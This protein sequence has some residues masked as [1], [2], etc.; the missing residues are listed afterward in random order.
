M[1]GSHY[2][3]GGPP[4][5]IA[6]IPRSGTSWIGRTLKHTAGVGYLHEPDNEKAH[7]FSLAAKRGLGRFPVLAP[8]ERHEA[9]ER[10]WAYALGA[11]RR[12]RTLPV[13]ARARTARMLLAGASGDDLEAAIAGRRWPV[14]LRAARWSSVPRVPPPGTLPVVKSVHAP[15]ALE[16]IDWLWA[17][18]VLV[19]FRH[20]LN[21]LASWLHLGLADRDRGL[22]RSEAVV[23]RYVRP[24]GVPLLRSGAGPLERAAWHYGLLVSALW[25]SVRSNPHWEVVRHE[26][27]CVDPG[28]SMPA[29]AARLGLVWTEGASEFLATSNRPGKGYKTHRIA[30]EQI[31]SWRRKLK[32]EEAMELR[33]VLAY[34][35]LPEHL[36]LSPAGTGPVT[37]AGTGTV[38]VES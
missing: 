23:E 16:W 29:L 34:F 7:P 5:L 36:W 15:L 24:W 26:E 37:E 4:V 17:P 33:R 3:S 6:G 22:D 13:R 1:N 32:E 14:R 31:E 20:P 11:K 25:Q 10:L 12:E 28:S 19:V 30:S 35:P 2:G 8:G 18:R 27:L 38:R 9:Y 21:T